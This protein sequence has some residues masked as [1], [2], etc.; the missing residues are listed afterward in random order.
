[1]SDSYGSLTFPAESSYTESYTTI[2]EP[3]DFPGN[4]RDYRAS[5]VKVQVVTQTGYFIG[6]YATLNSY[7]AAFRTLTDGEAHELVCNRWP[8]GRD[9]VLADLR[10]DART[11][12]VQYFTAT[13]YRIT[14]T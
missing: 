8:S 12:T 13:Y 14:K 10:F 1:M 9:F 4:G 6:T 2:L 7:M 5:G 11:G 3:I